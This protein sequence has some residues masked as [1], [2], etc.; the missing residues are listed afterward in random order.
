LPRPPR[1]SLNIVADE[2]F[3]FAKSQGVFTYG[4]KVFGPLNVLL[5]KSLDPIDMR[6]TRYWLTLALMVPVTG[7]HKPPS[8]P[9]SAQLREIAWRQGDVDDAFA[10]A[11]ESGKPV[12]LYW[13]AKWCPPCNQLK[14]TLFKNPTFIA[15]TFSFVPV[16]LDGDSQG[17]QRWG[18]RFGIS[19]YPTVIL[20]RPDGSEITRLSSS[21]SA[22]QLADVMHVAAARTTSI[23]ALLER[24]KGDLSTLSKDDWRLLADFDWQ[25]DPR[26]FGDHARAGALLDRLASAAPDPALR[27]RFGL[28]ALAVGG[29]WKPNE[30]PTP[31]QQALIAEILP[32]ILANPNEVTANRQEL[33]F[34]IAPLI[35]AFPNAK[36]R[37]VLGIPLVAAL[38]RVYADASLPIPDRLAT[39]AAD[40]ALAK[41][42]GSSVPPDVL[43]KVRSRVGWA[44]SSAK[45]AMVRQ[46]VISSAADLLHEAGDDAA[47]KRLLEVELK[48]S[49]SPYYYMLDLAD[50]AEDEKDSRAAIGWARK[51]YET[52]QGPATRVQWAIAYSSTVLRLAPRDK[53]AVEAS[54]AV[55]ID[56]LGKN[57]D[58]YYQRTRT[59]VA[60]WGGLLHKW[61][62][63]HGGAAVLERLESRMM[64][65]C[66]KQGP[67]AKDC[68][69]WMQTA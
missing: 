15:E 32:G 55:V 34:T 31:A 17:A 57:P 3:G 28:L 21:A 6:L 43:A 35:A 33:T 50:I 48:R 29:Q 58:S 19:G 7:C 14:S 24:A 10:E 36:Q 22:S 42:D 25:N 41:G 37:E 45:D 62:D 11:N 9:A 26:H 5:T 27:R 40:I 53:A 30:A 8:Q 13:G 18:E 12:F 67:Q 47:A 56:E 66:A 20:L 44:D 65:V 4:W 1:L 54:A 49:A 61:S 46:S 63:A 68:Q 51:A 60:S 39:V 69:N 52:A 23:E 38:D 64:S 16:Y 59:K 2:T